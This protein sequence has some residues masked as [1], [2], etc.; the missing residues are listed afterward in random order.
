MTAFQP[1]RRIRSYLEVTRSASYGFIAALPLFLAYEILILLV[2]QGSAQQVRVGA[3]LWIKQLIAAVG[4]SGMFVVGL[5]VMAA[6]VAILLFERKRKL[7]WRPAWLC[8]MLLESLVYAVLVAAVVANI[9]QGLFYTVAPE[10]AL[11]A[12]EGAR[13][14]LG[15]MLALSLGAGLYEELVFR[16]VLV[17]GMAWLLAR[18]TGNR[19]MSY[20]VAAVAGALLFSAVHYVGAFGDPFTL[21]SFTF[22][23]LFGITLNALYLA[24]GFGVAAWTHALYDV[25]V[26]SH[27]L[28]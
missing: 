27:L 10:S 13:P 28:T 11:F 9:V 17:G 12:Q 2:N 14:G 19:R 18:A 23:F 20:V 6:G 4:G 22:R 7:P 25:M 21:P 5:V 26:V 1:D 8:W 24:R 3:D 16:V 15:Q